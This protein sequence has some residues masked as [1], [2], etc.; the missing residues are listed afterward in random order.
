MPLEKPVV[1]PRVKWLRSLGAKVNTKK[2][3]SSRSRTNWLCKYWGVKCPDAPQSLHEKVW[4]EVR[5]MLES[6][7]EPTK[8]DFADLFVSVYGADKW[9]IEFIAFAR[10]KNFY[11][12]QRWKN[13]RFKA[14]AIQKKCGLCGLSPNDGAVL[15][16]DHIKP[17]TI[18][19]ELALNIDNLQV[20]CMDC[21]SGKGNTHIKDF[22]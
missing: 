18:Y 19:P 10:S 1:D 5:W 7:R 15:S 6:G 14:L 8:D 9:D 22:R 3:K 20:L 12:S 13:L 17:R 21:N 11:S 16:V 2:L 4:S